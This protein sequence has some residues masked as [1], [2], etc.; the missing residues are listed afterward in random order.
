MEIER[1]VKMERF[2]YPSVMAVLMEHMP[3]EAYGNQVALLELLYAGYVEDTGHVFDH[4]QV[5]KWLKGKERFSP[6]VSTYYMEQKHRYDLCSAIEGKVLPMMDDPA[7]VAQEL[8]ELLIQ[9]SG[10]SEQ[11]KLELTEGF[12]YDTTEEIALFLTQTLC[13]AMARCAEG[14]ASIR[15]VLQ[16]LTVRERIIGGKVPPPCRWFRGREEELED[17]H[18]LLQTEGKIFLHGIPGIGKSE[19]AKAYAGRYGREYANVLYL[20]YQGSLQDTISALEFS[21][22]LS[23]DTQERRFRRH[24]CCLRTLKA[25]TLLII[26]DFNAMPEEDDYFD[27]ILRWS[28]RI[29]F[30]TRNR[31]EDR[32]AME[33]QELDTESLFQMVS[34]L[35][36]N[37]EQHRTTISDIIQILHYHTFAVELAAR[38][39]EKGIL[40]PTALRRKLRMERAAMDAA[41]LIRT[42]KDG[43]SYRA[44]YHDHIR[45]LFALFRL[46]RQKQEIIRS[47]TL[48]PD[49]GVDATAFAEWL[50]LPSRNEINDLIELGLIHPEERKIAL[51]PMIREVAQDEL[52]PTIRKC[53]ELIESIHWICR[54]HSV[55]EPHYRQMFQTVERIMD[56]AGKDDLPGY[57]RFLEDV[58]PYME[59]YHYE[60]GMQKILK[61]MNGL[62]KED[63]LGTVSDRALLLDYRAAMEQDR[64]RA[65][66]LE[67]EAIRRLGE[68]NQKTALLAANLHSN[69]GELYHTAGELDLAAVHMEQGFFLMREYGL[70]EYHDILAQSL[71]YAMLL[72]ERREYERAIQFLMK[73]TA[74]LQDCARED[75][76]DYASVLE[77]IALL[78]MMAGKVQEG[79]TYYQ[80]CLSVWEAVFAD[81]PERIEEKKSES[82]RNLV[83]ANRYRLLN[84]GA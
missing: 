56:E 19:L 46:S 63:R 80:K 15:A 69:L 64:T 13:F 58:F 24:E 79:L 65:I 61:E 68:I 36:S 54:I 30:T 29:L 16:S 6:K 7:M 14:R 82:R 84:G 73:L 76:L 21:D 67:I 51:H 41:D 5:N 28:C 70:M 55:E 20:Y 4:G 66:E 25:D 74:F 44:T 22:D 12:S 31:F 62:L 83:L 42:I 10:V 53:R 40:K 59:K 49:T 50:K 47:M 81:E 35:H 43:K 26:D 2:D 3:R 32:T 11:K 27:R 77:T 23:T 72:G 18:D 39:L 17:L 48:V 8:Y 75:T 45:M 1:I 33:L 38:L 78:Y 71:N 57:L 60:S 37:A 9:D 34:C 52:P